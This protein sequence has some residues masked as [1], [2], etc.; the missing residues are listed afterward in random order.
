MKFSRLHCLGVILTL[1]VAGC[2]PYVETGGVKRGGIDTT[3]TPPTIDHSK[4]IEV[5]SSKRLE[6]GNFVWPVKGKV[7][8]IFGMRRSGRINKGIDIQAE[9]G[10]EVFAAR[11]GTVSF[12]HES[13]P[14]F[15]KTIIVDHGDQF[16][17]VYA[18]VGEILVHQGQTVNQ[19]QVIARVGRTGPIRVPALHFE[20][21]RSQRP[22]NPF[23][24]LS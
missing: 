11:S 5:P 9:D 16:A 17:T 6:K 7:I 22:Q 20:I 3:T 12:V 2:T 23:Y 24:Y 18:Y 10:A 15:G 4:K 14:G 8:S 13:L 1:S 19:R 21:R